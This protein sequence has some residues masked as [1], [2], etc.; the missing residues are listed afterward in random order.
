MPSSR[1]VYLAKFLVDCR[2]I[3]C[4]ELSS[5]CGSE[6]SQQILLDRLRP[7]WLETLKPSD[8]GRRKSRTK[9]RLRTEFGAQGPAPVHKHF[10]GSLPSVGV[11]S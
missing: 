5:L 9:C 1:T 2:C 8:Q 7:D 11:L 3:L 4:L 10:A 6:Q